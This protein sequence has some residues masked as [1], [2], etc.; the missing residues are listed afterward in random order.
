MF[1][2]CLMIK[3]HMKQIVNCNV[4]NIATL[5]G[6]IKNVDLFNSS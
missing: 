6:T 1:P 5:T 2:F 4:G 3:T